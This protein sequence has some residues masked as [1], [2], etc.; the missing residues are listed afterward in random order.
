MAKKI[1]CR[2]VESAPLSGVDSGSQLP[3]KSLCKCDN[4]TGTISASSLHKCAQNSAVN[5]A[6]WFRDVLFA[7]ADL[8]L[9]AANLDCYA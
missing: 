3:G 1:S 5:A 8:P 2:V 6:K 9:T 4:F 7:N